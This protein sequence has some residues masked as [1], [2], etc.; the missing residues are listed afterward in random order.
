MKHSIVRFISTVLV[1]V[2]VVAMIAP[3]TVIGQNIAEAKAEFETEEV[4]RDIVEQEALDLEDAKREVDEAEVIKETEEADKVEEA[5]VTEEVGVTEDIETARIEENENLSETAELVSHGL[6]EVQARSYDAVEQFVIRLYRIVLNRNY[7]NNGLNYW[8]S[9][10][11]NGQRTASDVANGFFFS[12]EMQNRNLGNA[13]YVDVLYRSILGREPDGN[14]RVYWIR[15]LDAGVPR[16]NIV[17]G[18]TNSNEFANMAAQAGIPTGTITP[19][20]QAQP[21]QP[22][23]PQSTQ[24]NEFVARLYR[25]VLGR[26]GSAA[27]VNGWVNAMANGATGANVIRGFVFSAEA[28]RRNLNNNQWTQMVEQ[29]VWNRGPTFSIT[30][31]MGRALANGQSRHE[32]LDV[33]LRHSDFT[34]IRHRYNL[35]IATINDTTITNRLNEFRRSH[36]NGSAYGR[37]TPGIDCVTFANMIQ[38]VAFPDM[39]SQQVAVF[40]NGAAINT[41][42][43][44]LGDRISF[45]RSG[46]AGHVGIVV[47]TNPLRIVHG[48]VV[49]NGVGRVSWDDA[50]N[51]VNGGY[52][53]QGGTTL[54]TQ[55]TIHSRW[56]R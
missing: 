44:R 6:I 39:P 15:Q 25:V 49:S 10:L 26:E 40:R 46:Q 35:P 9:S 38:R 7:D 22:T 17:A 13:D 52:R 18:F 20:Q 5:D 51:V 8:V 30:G 19:P 48:N 11:K 34:A 36:P 16:V 2:L 27:E 54:W 28:E 37:P 47:S 3:I 41:S 56:A 21:Q 42:V 24:R 45:A 43:I 33:A 1:F 55:I 14:G 32:A 4:A 23:P 50:I 29:A 53:I 12:N 31:S